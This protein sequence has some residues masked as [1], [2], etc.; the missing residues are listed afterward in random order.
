M[1]LASCWQAKG[2]RLRAERLYRRALAVD[3]KALGPE[4][5]ETLNDVR[6]LAEFLREGGRAK[7]AA[8][9][10]KRLTR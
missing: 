4:H 6:N 10:E 7:E 1:I 5:P 9:L 2:N 8:E 3:E